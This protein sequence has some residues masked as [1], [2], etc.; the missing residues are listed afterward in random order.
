M[1]HAVYPSFV[2]YASYLLSET[3]CILLL[4]G[5]MWFVFGAAGDG[6]TWKRVVHAA[7]AGACLAGSAL[8]RP[9]MLPFLVVVPVWLAWDAGK[10]SLKIALPASALVAALLVILP[11]ELKLLRE[12]GRL[13]PLSTSGGYNLYLGNNPWVPAGYGSAWGR[14]ESRAVR[15]SAALA[16]EGTT[17]NR[18]AG[19]LAREYI[20][21]H[22]AEFCRNCL[23]RLRM[24][25]TFDF[26]TLRHVVHGVAP[27]QP[28]WLVWLLAVGLPAGLTVFVAFC[29]RGLLSPTAPPC[30]T[31]LA[32]M[33]A[34]GMVPG[35]V[36]IG[37]P[38]LRLPLLALLLPLAGHGAVRIGERLSPRR[39]AVGCVVLCAFVVMLASSVPLVVRGCLLASSYYAPFM[40]GVNRLTGTNAFLTDRI[41]FRWTGTRA[42][43]VVWFRLATQSA[44]FHES[45]ERMAGWRPSCPGDKLVLNIM[46]RDGYEPVKLEVGT[47]NSEEHVI[48]EPV[49][50]ELWRTW[51]ATGIPDLAVT[52]AGGGRQ[53]P[54]E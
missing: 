4:L 15:R 5:G 47:Q 29:L 10:R 42:G 11:W 22:P 24:L 26:F 43:T 39:W 37:M 54:L 41:E 13:L 46:S 51:Q 28:Q 19:R 16:A 25:W 48:V 23:H 8:T 1:L 50:R 32:V 30:R 38:R 17:P 12:E 34:V 6:R 31:L 44:R 52:W 21:T 40:K 53:T 36:S 14:P 35:I 2:A 49:R 9:A 7:G 18:V 33:V 45:D 27:P 20:R 3:L